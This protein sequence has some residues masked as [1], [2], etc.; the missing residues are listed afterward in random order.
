MAAGARRCTWPAFSNEPWLSAE[1]PSL[2]RYV[3]DISTSPMPAETSQRPRRRRDGHHARA[4]TGGDDLPRAQSAMVPGDV[5][6]E[7]REN[8]I[9][10]ASRIAA[11]GIRHFAC[12]EVESRRLRRRVDATFSLLTRSEHERAVAERIGEQRKPIDAAPVREAGIDQLECCMHR[13]DRGHDILDRVG[14]FARGQI[15][16]EHEGDLGFDLRS[17]GRGVRRRFFGAKNERRRQRSARRCGVRTACADF[18]AA[19]RAETCRDRILDRVGVFRCRWSAAIGQGR[20]AVSSAT[21]L[22]Q[23]IGCLRHSICVHRSS[24][25]TAWSIL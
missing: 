23:Q 6:G 21:R 13:C 18:P 1:T 14:R 24:P 10:I 9:D 11:H 20:E 15:R 7:P 4:G 17:P 25:V 12:A 5:V 22:D 8:S 16:P 3:R 2:R 19:D